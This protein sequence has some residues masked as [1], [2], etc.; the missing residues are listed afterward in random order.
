MCIDR[1]LCIDEFRV[2][3]FGKSVN[4]MDNNQYKL[5]TS[6]L[7]TLLSTYTQNEMQLKIL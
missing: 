4:L 1:V 3:R 6:W 7:S 5:K 2:P